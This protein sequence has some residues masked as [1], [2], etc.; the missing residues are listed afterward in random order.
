M[1]LSFF[2]PYRT[3]PLVLPGAKVKKDAPL[4][5]CYLRHHPNPMIRAAPHHYEP[6]HPEVAMKHKVTPAILLHIIF[7][8]RYKPVMRLN[9]FS[10]LRRHVCDESRCFVSALLLKSYFIARLSRWRNRYFSV[11][12]DRM[13]FQRFGPFSFL[14]NF[15]L[16]Y[17][18]LTSRFRFERRHAYALVTVDVFR[19]SLKF[20]GS[21]VSLFYEISRLSPTV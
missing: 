4:G 6:A 11:S 9:F 12:S 1:S 3:T 7:R 10:F 14:F 17:L 13:K 5:E 15:F 19:K 21:F 18:F 8:P 16:F 2:Q 20:C